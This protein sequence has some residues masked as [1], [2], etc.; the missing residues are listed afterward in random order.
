MAIYWDRVGGL[1]ILRDEPDLDPELDGLGWR[2]PVDIYETAEAYVMAVELPGCALE[3]VRV[4]L[5]DRRVTV[6]GERSPRPGPEQCHRLERGQGFFSR[7]FA[8]PQPIDEPR[9]AAELKDGLLSVRLPKTVPPEPRRV[10][11]E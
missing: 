6:S 10:R 5:G 8:F 11:V 1:V 9:I 2:P 7:T 4:S 3:Q